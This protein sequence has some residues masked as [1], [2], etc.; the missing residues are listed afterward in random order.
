MSIAFG[1]LK[2]VI[3]KRFSF[4]F[5]FLENYKIIKYTNILRVNTNTF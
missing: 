5:L 4:L 2:L 1:K 3:K